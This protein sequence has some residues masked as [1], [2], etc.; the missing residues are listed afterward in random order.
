MTQRN[1]RL[2]SVLTLVLGFIWLA[3]PAQAGA[4]GGTLRLVSEPGDAMHVVHSA[5]ASARK[6]IDLEM[7]EFT[8]PALEA[9]LGAK[10]TSGVKVKVILDSDYERSYNQAAATYLERHRVSVVWAPSSTIYHAKFAVIDGHELLVGTGNFTSQYYATT[11]DFWIVDTQPSDVAAATSVFHADLSGRTSV[12]SP[13]KDLIFSP[14]SETALV[15]LINSATA[16][17][18]VENEEMDSY[19][20]TDALDAAAG[21]GVDVTVVMTYSSEWTSA[22][23]ELK[24]AG[25]HVFVDHGESPIYI[26]AKAICADCAAGNAN[27]RAFV[28]SENF[29]TSSL[30]YN[31][32]LGVLTSARSITTPLTATL[33]ADAASA[34]PW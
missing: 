10:A 18:Q 15:D 34:Q 25:V 2:L 5:F 3:N 8:D 24:A 17:L 1:F 21:R 6:S 7:Y 28:G 9:Q 11:R 26:H 27:A 16:T 23:N 20:I 31:R 33:S 29:S 22:F 12:V 4:S 19:A 13:G 14:G 30:D 32:E